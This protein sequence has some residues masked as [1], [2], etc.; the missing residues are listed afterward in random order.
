[1]LGPVELV[2]EVDSTN[3]VVM[4][5]ARAGAPAGLVLVADHQTAGRGRLGRVWEAP[6]GSSL[7]VS[8]L[9][10]PDVPV[11]Q[12]HLLTMAAALAAAEA[13]EQVAGVRPSLKWPNDLLLGDPERKLAGLLAESDVRG[14]TAEVVVLGMGLNVNWP[15]EIPA[16]LGD[17]ATSLNHHTGRAVDRDELLRGWLASLDRRL[18]A[19]DKV[20]DEYLDRCGTIGRRVRVDRAAGA[21][22]GAAVGID[23]EGALLVEVDGRRERIEAGDVVHVRAAD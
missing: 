20:R 3:R 7:L 16:G 8:V 12:T 4:E 13:C 21:L 22:E 18:G 14:E 5:R 17:V 10:R 11:D 2:A 1:M 19:L 23:G 6:P 9:L 15:D